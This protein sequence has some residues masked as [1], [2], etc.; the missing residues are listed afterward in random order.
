[1]LVAAYPLM[2]VFWSMMFFFL[3]VSWIMIL[4][5]VIGDLFRRYDMSGLA[6]G[7]WMLL[8]ILA[9]FIGVLIYIATQGMTDRSSRRGRAL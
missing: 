9:P 4:F 5:R 1:M 6:K 7:C 2:N 3:W 8:V